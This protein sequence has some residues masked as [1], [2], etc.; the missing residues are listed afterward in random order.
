MSFD[1][2][3]LDWGPHLLERASGISGEASHDFVVVL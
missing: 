3:L 2:L 1:S